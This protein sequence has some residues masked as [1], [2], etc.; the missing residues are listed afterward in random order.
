MKKQQLLGFA[1]G[2]TLAGCS[3]GAKYK[4]DDASLASV[5]VE[6]KQGVLS[7]NNDL[8]VARENKI[9][10]DADYRAASNDL[11]VAENDRKTANV[12]LDTARIK[13]KG[14]EQIADFNAKAAAGQEV[15]VGKLAVKAADAKVEFLAKRKKWFDRAV[16]AADAHVRCADTKKELEKARLAQAKGIRPTEKFDISQFEIEYA[17]QQK[18]YSDA[19]LQSDKMK[20]EVDNLERQYQLAQQ[21]YDGAR[22]AP[23]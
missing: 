6:E 19:Q 11:A 3:S 10:A 5:P 7:A 13:Q 22:N 12:T 23:R 9:K 8:A 20:P 1:L 21:T 18:N 4:V 16:D 17:Q 2:L 15:E 14:A